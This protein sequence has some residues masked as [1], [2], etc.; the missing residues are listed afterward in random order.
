LIEVQR[1]AGGGLRLEQVSAE[2]FDARLAAAY[3]DNASDASDAA[4]ADGDLASLADRTAEVDDLLDQSEDAPVVRLINALL[5]EAIKENASD[6][7]IETQERK[8][9]ACCARWWNPNARWPPCWSAAL[10]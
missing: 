9:V 3:R 2:M 8:L 1:V 10:R 7:H 6:I 4:G 5:L